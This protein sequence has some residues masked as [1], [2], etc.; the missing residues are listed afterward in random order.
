MLIAF[1][2]YIGIDE[3]VFITQVMLHITVDK[4]ATPSA[5]ISLYWY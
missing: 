1:S 3:A 5:Y 2:A 4:V